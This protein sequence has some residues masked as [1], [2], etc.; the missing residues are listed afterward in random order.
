MLFDEICVV[1][2]A[3]T[4]MEPSLMV[5]VHGATSRPTS[6]VQTLISQGVS[7]VWAAILGHSLTRQLPV[8]QV[9]QPTGAIL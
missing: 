8:S 3:K 9:L 4:S 7:T 1:L 6:I 2:Q 5:K